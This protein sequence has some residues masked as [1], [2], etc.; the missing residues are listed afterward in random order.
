[1]KQDLFG[2]AFASVMNIPSKSSGHT[3]GLQR[4]EFDLNMI[5]LYLRRRQ[6]E[7]ADDLFEQYEEQKVCLLTRSSPQ[8]G[9]E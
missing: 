5:R 9:C 1:M 4:T 6:R 8:T 3:Q 2:K 7:D